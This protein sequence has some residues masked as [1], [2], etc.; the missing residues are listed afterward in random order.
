MNSRIIQIYAILAVS[1]LLFLI[2]LPGLSGPYVLDDSENVYLNDAIA[3]KDL[4]TANLY[5]AL[6]ANESGPLLRPLASLSFALNHYFAGGFENTLPF[7]LTNL[8]IH[9]GNTALIYSLVLLLLQTPTL[10]DTSM[11]AYPLPVA[12]LTSA[13]WASHPIQ[14][15]NVLYVAQRMNSLSAMGVLIGL[16]IFMRG[17]RLVNENRPH[18]ITIMTIGVIL[19]LFLGLISKENAALLPLFALA[20][21]YVFYRRDQLDSRMRRHLYAFYIF[22]VMIPVTI[23]GIYLIGHPEFITNS[24]ALR[25]FTLHERLLTETRVLWFY[26]G[27]LILPT[28]DRLGLFHDDITLSTSLFDPITTLFAVAGLGAL[29]L[30]ALTKNKRWPVTSFAILWFLAGHT[31][32]SSVFGLELSYEHRNYLP[33]LGFFFL[34]SFMILSLLQKTKSAVMLRLLLPLGLVLVLSF[35]TWNRAGTWNNLH[36]LAETSAQHHPDSPR[37]NDFASKANL[38]E[39][40]DINR[41]IAYAL[42]TVASAP[43]EPGS[44]IYLQ[45][46]LATAETEINESLAKSHG[47]NWSSPKNIKISGLPDEIEIK[48]DNRSLRLRH[49]AAAA[50]TIVNL[51]K[52]EPITVHTVVALENLRR[53]VI[54]TPQV[55]ALL[56][57]DALAWLAIAANN[58]RSSNDYRAIVLRDAAML[59]AHQGH[60]DQALRYMEQAAELDPGVLTYRLAKTEYLIRT[61]HMGQ[62]KSMLDALQL[63]VAP[64]PRYSTANREALDALARMYKQATEKPR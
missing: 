10:R 48:A 21:E 5:N 23:F 12:A 50:Q 36:T 7:K 37:A 47:K 59:N 43:Q 4:S 58:P 63:D 25:H 46:L 41:A 39:V 33:S 27:L 52:T 57:A 29:S 3:L 14:L 2:Y 49:E 20:I 56:Q 40:N 35:A 24:Y 32:E 54:D 60:Y 51:L 53:C 22:M 15:T 9:I 38:L 62:A 11:G 45:L 1:A 28:P 19:G 61:G 17:R 31:L 13:L 16:L 55:C 30:F 34:V 8:L 26:V 18:G 6:R 64:F 44:R 42:K